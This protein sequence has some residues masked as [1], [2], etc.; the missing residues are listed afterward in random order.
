MA[1]SHK[2]FWG[3]TEPE[4]IDH[5]IFRIEA[6]EKQFVYLLKLSRQEALVNENLKLN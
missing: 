3:V 6:A 5:A 1:R 2:I 4:L